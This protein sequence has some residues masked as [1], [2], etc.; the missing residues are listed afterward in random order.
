MGRDRELRK[1]MYRD[2][3][4]VAEM[5]ELDDLGC[6]AC[7]SHKIVFDMVVCVDARNEAKQKG[8]PHAGHRCRFFNEK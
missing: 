7:L 2:P 1:F 5:L 4:Y 6:R 8:V 3:A